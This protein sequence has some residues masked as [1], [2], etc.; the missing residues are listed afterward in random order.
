MTEID[1][2]RL[3]GDSNGEPFD[4]MTLDMRRGAQWGRKM[5]DASGGRWM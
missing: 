3:E 5:C 2:V 4:T 1:F